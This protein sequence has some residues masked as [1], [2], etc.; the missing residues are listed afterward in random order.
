MRI[1]SITLKNFKR[2]T[3]LNLN[4]GDNPKKIIA[5]IGPNGCGKSS[6]FDAFDAKFSID[7]LNIYK[8]DAEFYKKYSAIT[9]ILSQSSDYNYREYNSIEIITHPQ[10]QIFD[11]T[12][13]YIRTAHR[14]TPSLNITNIRSL[15][16]VV[17]DQNRPQKTIDIDGRLKETY[18]RLLGEFFNDMYDQDITGKDWVRSKI[19]DINDVLSKVLDIEISFL[20]NPTDGRG[21]LY[22]NKGES[23]N[24]PYDLLS[25]GEKE[26]LNLLLDL[27]VKTRTYTNT[28]FCIDEPELHLNTSIQRKLLIELEKLINDNC[29]L[30]VATHS[31]GFMRALQD[32][33]QD[34]YSVIDMSNIDFD[35]HVDLLPMAINHNTWRDIFSTALD[36]LSALIAPKTIIYCEGSLDNSLDEMLFNQI[37]GDKKDCLFVSATNKEEL[38]RCAFLALRIINKVFTSKVKLIGL[39]DKDDDSQ[40]I[41]KLGFQI[42]QLARRE[43]E[44]YLYD[45]EIFNKA[46]PGQLRDI[47]YTK[48]I[49]D[50]Q[51]DRVKDKEQQLM[52]QVGFKYNSKNKKKF[53]CKLATQMSSETKIYQQLENEIFGDV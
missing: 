1:K 26:V 51:N 38:K 33:K 2:F 20:G 45:Y 49:G 7:A 3:S 35:K 4:L 37:F 41:Q 25:A 39:V 42:I 6:I 34:Q 16:P 30:W 11:K 15:D 9:P 28:I 52:G 19:K 32:M 29:Q 27:K 17:N 14:F 50:I 46:F 21:K 22:F 44:N 5:L 10:E 48:I 43:F 53:K 23:K 18:E 40:L 8:R 47:E 24:F 36:D 13:L 12:S 31:I